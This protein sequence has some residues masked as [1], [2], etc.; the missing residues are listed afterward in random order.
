[1]GFI[2]PHIISFAGVQILKQLLEI[3]D[4]SREYKQTCIVCN[5]TAWENTFK[6]A[7]SDQGDK[8]AEELL[9]EELVDL[10]TRHKKLT[11]T[12]FMNDTP[13]SL[14]G[15]DCA[16]KF[17]QYRK[18]AKVDL[19][20]C[21][22]SL[23]GAKVETCTKIHSDCSKENEFAHKE[24][25]KRLMEHCKVIG[26]SREAW[27]NLFDIMNMSENDQIIKEFWKPY[28]STDDGSR[29]IKNVRIRSYL[30]TL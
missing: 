7:K 20:L 29:K 22:T 14:A 17:V 12:I 15:H 21:V 11:I 9:L 16:G 13:C 8:H 27:E 2:L 30:D 28:E 19:T 26:P 5:I 10:G 23:C 1:M 25:L 4:P 6:L 24:G 3:K 18:T